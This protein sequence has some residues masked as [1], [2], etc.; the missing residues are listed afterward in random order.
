MSY[1]IIITFTNNETEIDLFVD[2]IG[3][4]LQP[5]FSLNENLAMAFND[6][7]QAHDLT[8]LIHKYNPELKPAV[9]EMI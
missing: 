7:E 9:A 1:I 6:I 4:N 8:K 2:G 3:D 5:S